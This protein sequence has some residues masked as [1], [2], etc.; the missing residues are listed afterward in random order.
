MMAFYVNEGFLLFGVGEGGGGMGKGNGK[1]ER[2]NGGEIG[3]GSFKKRICSFN[4]L[5]YFSWECAVL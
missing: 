3:D 5:F 1:W 4:F 2:G